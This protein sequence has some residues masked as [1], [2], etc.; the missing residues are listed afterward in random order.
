MPAIFPNFSR[1]KEE[2]DLKAAQEAERK[3]QEDLVTKKRKLL[4]ERL[5]KEKKVVA[6]PFPNLRGQEKAETRGARK[7]LG[8]LSLECG[9][10]EHFANSPGTRKGKE[11]RKGA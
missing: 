5:L 1:K 8:S 9:K 7:T 2:E 4:E 11:A 10:K 3:A 6:F